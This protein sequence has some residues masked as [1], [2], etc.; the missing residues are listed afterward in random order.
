MQ[1]DADGAAT[2]RAAAEHARRRSRRCRCVRG[3]SCRPCAS[4][5]NAPP[6]DALKPARSSTSTSR[7]D[8]REVLRCRARKAA[9]G[10]VVL[11]RQHRAGDVDERPP[12]FTSRAAAV[13]HRRLLLAAHRRGCPG[14]GAIW[15]P[16]CGARCRSRCRAHRPA[17]RS[18][19]PS[20]SASASA[21]P[22]GVR[23]WTLRTP[24]RCRR[25]WIGARRRVSL[26][27]AK[28]WPLLSIS[29][30]SASVLPPPRR[31]GRAPARPAAR[32]RAARRAAS[33]RPGS[34]TSP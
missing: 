28:I 32:R 10:L 33:P 7:H 20:R 30:A 19:L 12:G 17:R 24:A 9:H 16:G 14:A 25:S 22:R 15:R 21:V 4:S 27:V 2:H 11:L 3:D 34:R 26:S 31:R 1:R 18:S 5:A 13:E 6:L 23:T 29:A 8:R